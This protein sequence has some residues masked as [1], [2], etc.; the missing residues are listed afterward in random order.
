MHRWKKFGP[1]V[2]IFLERAEG[3]GIG[4]RNLEQENQDQQTQPKQTTK[5]KKRGK[6]VVL[7]YSFWGGKR[8]KKQVLK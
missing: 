7:E 2:L 1:W 3:K 6:G 8:E 4:S 5:K